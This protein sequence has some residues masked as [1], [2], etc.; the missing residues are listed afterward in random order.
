M[1]HQSVKHLDS[2]S[3]KH[4]PFHSTPH[5]KGDVTDNTA[6]FF[7]NRAKF[8]GTFIWRFYTGPHPQV[9]VTK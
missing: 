2:D 1:F 7:P 9:S 6:S 4:S 5:P 3:Y 8:K